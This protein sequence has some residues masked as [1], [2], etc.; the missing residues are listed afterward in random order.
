MRDFD[1]NNITAAVIDRFADTP[2]PRLKEIMSSLVRHLH[3]FACDVRL[4]FAEWSYPIDFSRAQA[5]FAVTSARSSS[6]CPIRSVFPCSW[7][8]SII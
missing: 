8:P 6:S 1:E 4:S 2:D 7:M 3:A 5:K